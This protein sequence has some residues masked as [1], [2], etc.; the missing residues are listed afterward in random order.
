M[1]DAIEEAQSAAYA[2]DTRTVYTR[3]GK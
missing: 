1:P 3:I 2:L